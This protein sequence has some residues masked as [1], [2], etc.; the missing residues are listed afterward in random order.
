M[1]R[2][3]CVD[4]GIKRC[5]IANTDALQ[6]AVHPVTTVD[7]KELIS[8][9]KNYIETEEV[10]KLVFGHPELDTGRLTPMVQ[11]MQDT[12]A[13]LKKVVGDIPIV[14]HEEDYTSQRASKILVQSG[15]KK[16][17]RREKGVLDRLSAVLILQDYLGH[18]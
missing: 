3:V 10:E 12:I 4:Y 15:V 6:I 2:I 5:G 1:A 16:K 14:F 11:S 8:F 13:E 9:L 7:K 17:K 18:Y